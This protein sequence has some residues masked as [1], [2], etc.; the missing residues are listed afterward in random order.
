MK[1]LIIIIILCIIG[2][3][4]FNKI[5]GFV[6]KLDPEIAQKYQKFISFYNPF[7]VSWE[8]AI[9][10]SIGL[11]TPVKE[12][13]SPSQVSKASFTQPSKAEMNQYI[14][15]MTKKMEKPFPPITE[16]LPDNIEPDMIEEVIKNI[17]M[18]PAIYRNALN[19]MNR[20]LE[21][22]QQQLQAMKKQPEGFDDTS[23]YYMIESFEDCSQISK[24]LDARDAAKAQKEKERQNKFGSA[25]DEFNNDIE[26][27]ASLQ[28]NQELVKKAKIIQEQAQSGEL[29][30]QMNL[31][32]DKEPK[33]R[34]VLPKGARYLE[35]MERDD[36]EKYNSYKENDKQAFYM[37]QYTNDI[38]RNLR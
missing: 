13:T 15:K 20:G 18:K 19:W 34:Y 10:T 36:P 21:E 32:G 27:Q 26:L 4:Y 38:N 37:A 9:I 6:S 28:K 5:E 7:L 11:D 17:P 16:P 29:L 35:D 1:I 14:Q 12:L 33:T 2:F 31:G 30:G 23:K 3:Y 24:C 8:K 22:A 25:L